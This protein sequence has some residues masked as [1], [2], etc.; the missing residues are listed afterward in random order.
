MAKRRRRRKRNSQL[1]AVLVVLLLVIVVGAAGIITAYIK[2]Y[3]PSDARMALKDY[4]QIQSE[5]EVV[6]ILQDKVSEIRG[7]V[8]DKMVYIPYEVVTDTLG[9]RFYWDEESQKVLY[10]TPEEIWELEP[11]SS[12]YVCGKEKQEKE[13]EIVR[14]IDGGRYIALNFLEE[15]MQI[16]GAIYEKPA[17][18][19]ITYQW[20]SRKTL[21]AREDTVIR[22]QGGIKSPILSDVKAGDSLILLEEMENWSRVMTK[23]GLDGYVEK[24]YMDK[25]QDTEL[26]YEG[27]YEENYTSL[28]RD[29]KINLAWH[30]VT[31]ESA[32]A[33]FEEAVK[34]AAGVNVISPTW[35]SVTGNEGTISSLASAEYVSKAHAKGMEVWGLID[36]FNENISTLE[37][38]S[39][40]S[41]RTHIIEKLLQEAKR[42]GLDGINVDFEALTEEEV[43]H[44][45]QFLRELSITCRANNLVLSIDNPVPQYT[46]FYNRKEQGIIGDYVIIMGYDEHTYGSPKA[47]SVASLPFVEEGIRLTLEEVPEEKVING[48]PFYTRLWTEANNGTV[49]SKVMGMEE[50]SQYTSEKGM[51]VYWN[52][53]VSQ[54]YGE[55]Q[56]ENG[57]ERI[58][59]EDEESLEAKMQL[60]KEYDLAGCAAWKLGFERANVWPVINQYLQ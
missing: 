38:L 23:D 10:T 40:R 5:D 34:D 4:Y 52:K 19:V 6:L 58:W 49:S 2:K 21:T 27:S 45:I 8:A 20:G 26:T 53:E 29:Y 32:N 28:T 43:P 1:M 56:T 7:K 51:D 59:L 39:A 46:A 22:Y 16:Q 15:Y 33:A 30:Q 24:K 36:N 54:N 41:S 14:E 11:G 50:A 37:T 42:V 44:F 60:I 55:I 13:Y 48:V 12:S 57:L 31:S 3:T 17:R 18:T 47:G 35:F 25:P 9:G